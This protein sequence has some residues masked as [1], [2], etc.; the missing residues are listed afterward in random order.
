MTTAEQAQLENQH[1]HR[2]VDGLQKQLK[3]QSMLLE[4]VKSQVPQQYIHLLEVS[5][6]TA[7]ANWCDSIK[8]VLTS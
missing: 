5:G 2:Q 8:M 3:T 4:Q 7:N 1:L 6:Q